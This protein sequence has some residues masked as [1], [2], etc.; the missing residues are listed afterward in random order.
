MDFIAGVPPRDEA[1]LRAAGLDPAAIAAL[2]ADIVLDMV[3]INGRFHA[4]PHPGNL[5]C[6]PGNRIALLDLGMIG[7]VSPRRREEFIAFVQS[8]KASDPALLAD[9]L[10][11]WSAD[12]E[13]PRR[14]AEQAAD[15][16]IAR[17]SGG[18][19]VLSAM[20]ADF[21]ALMRDEGMAMP[22]D[23]LLIFKALVTI[24]GVLTAIEPGFDL[25]AAIERAS[26][27]IAA[28][29]LSPEHW[30]PL[31]RS[32]AWEL[33]R[34]GGDAPRLVRALARRWDAAPEQTVPTVTLSLKGAY[35]NSGAILTG[36]MIIAVALLVAR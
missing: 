20:I 23:L 30:V 21:M 19:I 13:A 2:G 36:A 6:L 34:I 1:M 27:R 31:I 32:L 22:P 12:G 25:S 4:D 26:L 9:V 15:R 33:G 29:W 14:C 18:P 11:Q 24:D 7:H 5:L 17:H 10:R 3:L 8:L 35:W 28:A 16:L